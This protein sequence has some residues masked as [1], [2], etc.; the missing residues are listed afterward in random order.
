MLLDWRDL[1]AS[2]AQV[3]GATSAAGW[4]LNSRRLRGDLVRAV[5]YHATPVAAR[6]QFQRHI[7]YY[8]RHFVPIGEADLA[9]FLAGSLKLSRP[10]LLLTFDDGF[11]N[12]YDVAADLLDQF[13]VKGF[14][15]VPANFIRRSGNQAAAKEYVSHNLFLGHPPAD[16]SDADCQPMSW[17]DLRDLIR[18]GHSVGCHGLDHV[19][20]GPNTDEQILRREIVDAKSVL[21]DELGTP[22]SSFC[23]PF[24]TLSSYSRD[25]FALIQQHYRYA[26]TTFAAPLLVGDS[27]YVIDRAS[28]ESHVGLARARW[29]V[30]GPAEMY[31]R[32]R[33]RQFAAIVDGV[34]AR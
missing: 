7:D 18:R 24:G 17:D 21:E 20:L 27:P 22:V 14:F 34:D 11:K 28:V 30:Q 10:G 26:F 6:E 16:W 33:R 19:A 3:T 1:S 13:G 32:N 15:F 2:V 5:N 25:A 4:A 12:N 9:P 23:W 8:L 29:A 31:L